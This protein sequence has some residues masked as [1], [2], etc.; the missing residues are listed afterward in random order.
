MTEGRDRGRAGWYHCFGPELFHS[1]LDFGGFQALLLLISN[2]KLVVCNLREYKNQGETTLSYVPL[3]VKT[4]ITYPKGET[5]NWKN[6]SLART[7]SV[8]VWQEVKIKS[9]RV[10]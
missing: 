3:P 5:S 1:F 10:W 4:A 9:Y 8:F 2:S 7:C 6:S